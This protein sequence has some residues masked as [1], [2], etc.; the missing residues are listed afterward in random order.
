MKIS[1]N[2]R[3]SMEMG[4]IIYNLYHKVYS[5]YYIELY[6]LVIGRNKS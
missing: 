5:K 3:N 2:K 4:N 1:V 6:E